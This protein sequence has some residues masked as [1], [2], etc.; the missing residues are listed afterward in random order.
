M[1]RPTRKPRK[2]VSEATERAS[3]AAELFKPKPIQF[4]PRTPGQ[5]ALCE[6]IDANDIVFVDGPAGSGKTFMAVAKACES[7]AAKDVRSIVLIRPTIG[8]GPTTGYLPGD[9]NAKVSVYLRPLLDELRHFHRPDAIKE[10]IGDGTIELTSLEYARG[11]T[12]RRAVVI[13]DEAQNATHE[14]FR[15]FLTRLGEGSQYIITGDLSRDEAGGYRQC[16]LHPRLQGAFEHYAGRFNHIPG[17]GRVALQVADIVRHPLVKAM[18]A[19]G[20]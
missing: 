17:I 16:D 14:D 20:L 1:P 13:L 7:L 5:A 2:D 4:K 19:A 10:M 11:R 18:V 3:K 6:A 12:F 15:V 9:L 8:V